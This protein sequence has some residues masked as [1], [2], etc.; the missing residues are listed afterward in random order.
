MKNF[1]KGKMKRIMAGLLSLVTVGWF[2]IISWH[3][4]CRGFLRCTG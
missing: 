2:S 1:L 4:I 3:K